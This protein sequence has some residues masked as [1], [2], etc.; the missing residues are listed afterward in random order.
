MHTEPIGR[1]GNRAKPS[2]N[3][4]PCRCFTVTL[5]DHGELL[6]EAVDACVDARRLGNEDTFDAKPGSAA[7]LARILLEHIDGYSSPSE[8]D[9]RCESGERPSY[10]CD[11]AAERRQS[12]L[13]A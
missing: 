9:S 6:R 10:D 1:V 11:V 8:A 12:T 4:Q 2:I 7:L 13:S 5:V 3:G